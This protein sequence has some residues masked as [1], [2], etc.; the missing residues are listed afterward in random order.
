MTQSDLYNKQKVGLLR[1]A[2]TRFGTWFYAMI[3]VLGLEQPLKATI[4]QAKFWKL[5]L[6]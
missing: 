3:R 2:G 1:G 4:H 6:N 5:D